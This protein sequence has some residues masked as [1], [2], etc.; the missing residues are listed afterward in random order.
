LK[1][2]VQRSS[3]VGTNQP[4]AY[5]AHT[6]NLQQGERVVHE[7]ILINDDVTDGDKIDLTRLAHS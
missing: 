7:L 4:F 5:N 2:N 6:L 1:E 3:W